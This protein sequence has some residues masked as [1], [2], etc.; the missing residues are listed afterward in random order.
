MDVRAVTMAAKL[1]FRGAMN[2]RHA[3]L[4]LSLLAFSACTDDFDGPGDHV[5]AKT[6]S[7]VQYAGCADLEID[8]KNMVTFEIWADID[9]AGDYGRGGGFG[10]DA[11]GE[12]A[13][14][15]NDGGG[16]QEGVDY[17]GT[18]NQEQG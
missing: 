18:N 1:L 9:R 10:E 11:A 5:I 7:L 3:V 12:G 6:T 8:L 2:F 13:G 4:P 16:R 15:P 17:S 14:A